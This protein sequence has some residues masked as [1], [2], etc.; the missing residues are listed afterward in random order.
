MFLFQNYF[1]VHDMY[2]MMA[3]TGNMG[4]EKAKK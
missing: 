3:L 4:S 2:Y 1:A